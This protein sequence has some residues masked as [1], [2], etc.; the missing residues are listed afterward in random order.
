MSPILFAGIVGGLALVLTAV[1]TPV[2]RGMAINGGLVRDVQADRWHDRPTPAI[3]G[4]AIFIGFGVAISVGYLLDPNTTRQ[5][6]IHAAAK[7]VVPIAPWEGLLAA[8]TVAFVLGLVDD[9]RA[10]RPRTKLLGQLAAASVL[11]LSG[12]G[13]WITDIYAIDAVISMFW[14][15]GI[16]NAV[17]LLDNMDGVAAGVSGIAAGYLALIFALEGQLPL[18]MFALALCMSLLGFLAHNYPPA[19]IFMGDSGSL[20][21]GLSLAGLALAP[22]PGGTRS[23]AAVMAAPV[24]ILGVPILDTTLVTI[25]RLLEGRPVSMG[26]KDHT[27]HRFVSMGLPEKRTAWLLWGLAAL[28]GGVG[29]LLRQ[30]E[31]GTALVL[32]GVLIMM[33][34]ITG[35]YLMSVRMQALEGSEEGGASAYRWLIDRQTRYPVLALGLDGVWIVLAYYSAYLLRWDPGEL[36]AEMPYFQQTVLVFVA[37]KLVGMVLAGIYDMRWSSMGLY[38]GLRMVRANVFATLLAA[39]FLFLLDRE[40]LSRGVIAIDLFVCMVLTIGGRLTFRVIQGTTAHLSEDGIP[41]VVLAEERHASSMVGQL[42]HVKDPKLRAVAVADPR[43]TTKRARMGALP[44]FGGSAALQTALDETRAT[45]V[46]L[47]GRNRKA[48]EHLRSH[49]DSQGGVD[50]YAYDVSIEPMRAP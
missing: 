22:A 15:I 12:I 26:G 44:L 30:A 48:H 47:V 23:L 50:V 34:A 6:G 19:R 18:A 41:V 3:G 35:A 32:G 28:G 27:S 43:L 16:T 49:L 14:F 9:F 21:V 39:G 42:A 7:A 4:I 25:G 8:A 2:V 36:G 40:G 11:L 33:L 24:L 38:D 13:L 20:F 31:R 37:I 1:L 17:N 29:V 10:L 45:A 46:L 5:F